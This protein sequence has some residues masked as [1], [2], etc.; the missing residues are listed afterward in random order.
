MKK[1]AILLILVAHI[2]NIAAQPGPEAQEITYPDLN[3]PFLDLV[4]DEKY[5]AKYAQEVH[6]GSFDLMEP[7]KCKLHIPSGINKIWQDAENSKL[8]NKGEYD[9][10]ND[11]WVGIRYNFYIAGEVVATAFEDFEKPQIDTGFTFYFELNPIDFEQGEGD[12]NF[13]YTEL[14]NKLKNGG[15]QLVIEAALPSKN[16]NFKSY[17][18]IAMGSFYLR[19]DQTKYTAWKELQTQSTIKAPA[20]EIETPNKIDY[21][22]TLKQLGDNWMKQI[23]GHA[24]FT[25]NFTMT[26]LQNPCA[27]GYTYANTMET[28][29]PCATEPQDSCMEAIITYRFIKEGVPLTIRMLVSIKDGHKTVFTENNQYGKE[30]ISLEQQNLLTIT[31]IRKII[32]KEFPKDS[33]VVLEEKTL[34]YGLKKMAQTPSGSRSKLDR[35]PV[36]RLIKET[37]AGEKWEG[38]FIYSAYGTNPNQ[39]KRIYHFDAVTGELLWIYEV[40]PVTNGDMGN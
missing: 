37:R 20:Q 9:Y 10:T 7:I 5:F 35:G 34:S 33:L 18:S 15:S 23:F 21:N 8:Y 14:I 13:A 31:E 28:D 6:S 2:V 29:N 36:N 27:S 39:L 19:F 16:L 4:N 11:F 22:T 24:G 12:I 40:F 1:I 17:V 32:S 38:G 30:E 3:N 26:C 25:T